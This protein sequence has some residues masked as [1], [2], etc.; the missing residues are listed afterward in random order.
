M[1]WRTY[2]IITR[3]FCTV[4][5]IVFLTL[6][7]SNCPTGN[8][9]VHSSHNNVRKRPMLLSW[10]WTCKCSVCYVSRPFNVKNFFKCFV[11][12]ISFF[13]FCNS[14]LVSVVSFRPNESLLSSKLSC[15]YSSTQSAISPNGAIIL[16]FWF[17]VSKTRGSLNFS[18]YVD[19][20]PL[21][22]S[23]SLRNGKYINSMWW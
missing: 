18:E 21:K 4:K 7:F 15:N 17:V 13:L 19:G 12:F 20:K 1:I 8:L 14:S 6:E 9:P 22:C 5:T 16:Q 23:Q 2:K 10:H 11:C 3:L